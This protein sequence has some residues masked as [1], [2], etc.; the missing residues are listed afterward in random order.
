MANVLFV[1]YAVREHNTLILT[2]TRSTEGTII[3]KGKRIAAGRGALSERIERFLSALS[4]RESDDADAR[5]LYELLVAP[6]ES[7][8]ARH[9]V[10]IIP[11]G[12]LWRLP[13]HALTDRSGAFLIE[14]RAIFYA[15]AMAM[16]ARRAPRSAHAPRELLAMGDPRID[17]VTMTS[18]REQVRGVTFTALPSAAGEVRGIARFYRAAATE[19]HTGAAA[20]EST[21]KSVAA[22]YRILHLATHGIADDSSPMYSSLLLARGQGDDEDGL[23]EA[24]EIAAMSLHADIAV[25]SACDTARGRIGAGEGVTG[26]SWAFLAAGCPTTVVSQWSAESTATA[27][28]MVDFHRQLV[29]GVT[30]AEALRRAELDLMKS[31]RYHHP[32]YW[33]PFVVLGAP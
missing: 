10:C 5:A 30:A 29:Q 25:L 8:I 18:I 7:E 4:R 23:L 17:R 14:R 1:E 26:L 32:Y 19:V 31:R 21:F 27:E 24:R 2:A 6:I 28:L 15:P 12:P 11:N 20:R 3:V 9:E 13:F 22:D 16:L 33:A